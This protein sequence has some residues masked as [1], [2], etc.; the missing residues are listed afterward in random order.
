MS[1]KKEE[2]QRKLLHLLALLMP[3][4]IFYIP[5]FGYPE[6]LPAAG[7]GILLLISI[8]SEY[9]RMKNENAGHLFLK[10]FGS[11][12]R[13]AEKKEVTGSTF[14]I[15]G[16]FI[17][18]VIFFKRPEI[19]FISLFLFI[20][21]DAIAAVVGLS[22]GKTKIMGKSLEGSLA[23]LLCCIINLKI[24]IPLFPG[25]LE[26]WKGTIPFSHALL[27]SLA[28]TVLELIPIKIKDIKL[29]DN[30]TAPVLTGFF[31]FLLTA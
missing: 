24:I 20:S 18:S 30:L 25:V 22:I 28:V 9:I 3:V 1:L 19:S 8:V 11:M 29:N 26:N 17:C 10:L 12:M 21:G 31:L 13:P 7:L 2:I 27:I 5:K 4:S 23:C 16:A 6:L 14:I 15:A